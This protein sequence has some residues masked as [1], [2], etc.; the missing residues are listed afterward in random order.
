[1]QSHW[2]PAFAGTTSAL[3]ARLNQHAIVCRPCFE[4]AS[5]PLKQTSRQPRI[6]AFEHSSAQA[7]EHRNTQTLKHSSTQALKHSST[8]ALEHS[9][10]GAI[11]QPCIHS[12]DHAMVHS[13]DHVEGKVCGLRSGSM[14]SDWCRLAQAEF[15]EGAHYALEFVLDASGE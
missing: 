2:V 7:S 10:I 9:S 12:R 13:R 15:V 11:V 6:R 5:F 8:R 14:R 3:F 1:M 4:A